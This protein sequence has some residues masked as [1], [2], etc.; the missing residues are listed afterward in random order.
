MI[1][2]NPASAKA[3]ANGVSFFLISLLSIC[4]IGPVRAADIYW[5]N[6]AGGNWSAAANWDTHIIPGTNDN[7]YVVND[8]SYIVTLN[9]SASVL[10]L[11]VGGMSG[12]QTFSVN[13]TTLTLSDTG[14]FATNTV[15]NLSGGTLG[16]GGT[17]TI[18]GTMNWNSGGTVI[19]S[20]VL[21][22]NGF[23]SINPNA[24][25]AVALDGRTVN[26]NC[27]TTWSGGGV[28]SFKNGSVINNLASG[29]FTVSCDSLAST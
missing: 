10:S 29:V 9:V 17:V 26:L 21:N 20:G 14:N 2:L 28:I 19:G 22:V 7:A 25:S 13:G 8:G 4:L 27:P 12:Q 24:V 3:H 23:L 1:C 5:T 6:T 16:G 15:I 11:T 18:N